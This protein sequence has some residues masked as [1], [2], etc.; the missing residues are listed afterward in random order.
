LVVVRKGRLGWLVFFEP[1][2]SKKDGL[3]QSM[4]AAPNL[5]LRSLVP[6]SRK[7][8]DWA[9][10][11]KNGLD[12]NNYLYKKLA[13][14]NIDQLPKRAAVIPQAGPLVAVSPGGCNGYQSS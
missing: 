8:E 9:E 4:K 2:Y 1:V 11:K 5:A 6:S 13:L 7:P 10:K 12:E 14:S 3:G